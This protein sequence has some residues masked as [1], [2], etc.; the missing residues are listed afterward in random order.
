MQ[1]P[2]VRAF[3]VRVQRQKVSEPRSQR[4]RRMSAGIAGRQGFSSLSIW[5]KIY[6]ST[7]SCGVGQG[8][9]KRGVRVI[10]REEGG[11]REQ[12]KHLETIIF[13]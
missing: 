3:V 5:V 13:L 2:N 7:N 4:V 12:R 1:A 8:N 11:R 6:I 10:A 9:R